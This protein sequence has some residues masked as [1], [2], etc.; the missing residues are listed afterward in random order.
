MTLPLTSLYKIKVCAWW[1]NSCDCCEPTKF[2]YYIPMFNGVE[3]FT[4]GTCHTIE[5]AKAAIL[6]HLLDIDIEE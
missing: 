4:D 2:E 6:D 3:I 5:A 1:D